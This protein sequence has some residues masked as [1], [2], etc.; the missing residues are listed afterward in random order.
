MTR[1]EATSL[2]LKLIEYIRDLDYHYHVLSEPKVTDDVYNGLRKQLNEIETL[3]PDLPQILNVTS[4]NDL[5]GYTP[6]GGRFAKLKHA[7][8]MLSLGNAFTVPDL[9]KWLAQLPLPLQ[10]VVETKL[11]GVSL[12]LTYIDGRLN[13][14]V[15][16]GD[17]ETGEDVTAQVWVIA[18]IPMVLSYSNTDVV[19][20][21]V[22]T[23]R[24]EVVVHHE[25]FLTFNRN[26]EAGKRKQ[27]KNPRNMASG[28]LRVQDARELE[29]RK[30]RFYAYSSEF[31]GGESTSHLDDMEQLTLYGFIPAPSMEINK[32]DVLDDAYIEALF[33]DFGAQR[34][35]YPYD[36]DGMVFKVNSYQVQ[37]ELGARTASPRWAIA[38]KFP[39]EEV[40]T[41]MHAVEFQ[42]G[43]TG[44]LTP[45][46]RL[47]PINVCGVTV[48]NL[49]LHNLDELRRLDLRN[50]DY[51]T[52]IRSGDVIPKITGV[53]QTL[54]EPGARSIYWPAV[55]PCCNFQTEVV[56]SEKDGSKLYCSNPGCIGRAQK[57]IEYQVSRDVLNLEDFGE[58]AAANIMAI[59]SMMTIWDVMQWDDRQ[60]AWIES[61][62][63]MRLKM[64]RAIDAARTQPLH[65]II[66]A[67][68]IEL[69]A[70]STAEKIARAL[71]SLEE[72]WNADKEQ[73]MQIADVGE[74]T[75]ASIMK[76]RYDNLGI[77]ARVYEAVTTIIN[78]DPIVESEFTNKSVVVTGS[79]FGAF[80]RKTVEAWLKAQGA[81][82]A[83]DVSKN[84]HLVMCGTS[85]TA[86]K[87]EEAK[88]S[89]VPYIVYDG[90]GH[91]ESTYSAIPDIQAV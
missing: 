15:T 12:S 62:A 76:W 52:L 43:R 49:T 56:T 48:S 77:L 7:F 35:T 51:I 2:Y 63:V 90:N 9:Q 89:N 40:V 68:G 69:V 84:T 42:I 73:L 3:H 25:D 26:A 5:V 71:G 50:N 38:Y 60:L 53:V 41:K 72:F 78:P 88:A 31:H 70:E 19:Y 44:V 65:R 10:I 32:S 75:V 61:S 22:V 66:T 13:K 82:V 59:D 58:A 16:R 18:G 79:N 11:D 55:C 36:I 17:G 83:K 6:V 46:A 14:A 45:V 29:Q 1:A 24:G 87:L 91:V 28:S 57:L 39:A 33:K 8:P 27:F 30:L 74:K 34:G 21:G 23:I 81:K 64:K 20:R 85:Y 80:K 4:P 54:R 67:F 37:R 47:E 86:R